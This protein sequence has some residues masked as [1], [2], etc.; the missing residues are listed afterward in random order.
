MIIFNECLLC[1]RYQ[2]KQEYGLLYSLYLATPRDGNHLV[3]IFPETKITLK[4]KLKHPKPT[5][6]DEETGLEAKF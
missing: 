6:K 3:P 4:A 1:T 2:A 5:N